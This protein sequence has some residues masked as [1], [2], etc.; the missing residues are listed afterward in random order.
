MIRFSNLQNKLNMQAQCFA[1]LLSIPDL[2]AEG[3]LARGVYNFLNFDAAYNGLIRVF[4]DN[5]L[6]S[7]YEHVTLKYL[8]IS[9][10]D[11]Q[12]LIDA[13]HVDIEKMAARIEPLIHINISMLDLI[14][15]IY[16]V[17]GLRDESKFIINTCAEFRLNWRPYF[18]DIE[19][20]SQVKYADLRVQN[21]SYRLIASKY[22]LKLF[23]YE[24]LEN[25]LDRQ[26]N[27]D[28]YSIDE[29]IIVLDKIEKHKKWLINS[30]LC[31]FGGKL[32][33]E[34]QTP[35]FFTI[36][37]MRYLVFGF[38]LTPSVV[39]KVDGSCPTLN[40]Q[41]KNIFYEQ[42]YVVKIDQQALVFEVNRIKTT[43]SNDEDLIDHQVSLK[44]NL[45]S[46]NDASDKWLKL[47]GSKFST[48]FRPITVGEWSSCR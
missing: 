42:K 24:H 38:L 5:K 43:L 16:K 47:K 17:L 34:Q 22:P 6:Q 18:E 27:P 29:E 13:L 2:I 46:H 12:E 1:L 10:L 39:R 33:C 20:V 35:M 32:P 28:V 26:L 11:D 31:F 25:Y 21:R 44:Q 40:L 36:S 8:L 45:M 3:I 4:S 14:S 41:I 7:I 9:E 15:C 48:A 37:G 23:S 30:L 19:D